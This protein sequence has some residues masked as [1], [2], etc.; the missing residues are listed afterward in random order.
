MTQRRVWKTGEGGT[1]QYVWA[2][3]DKYPR[4][5]LPVDLVCAAAWGD[6]VDHEF[7]GTSFASVASAETY[8][9]AMA[10]DRGWREVPR[11]VADTITVRTLLR[12]VPGSFIRVQRARG[13]GQQRKFLAAW[14]PRAST[15]FPEWDGGA[16]ATAID[17][18]PGEA[19]AAVYA[20]SVPAWKEGL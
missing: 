19:V 15:D 9:E 14:V 18:T 1:R 8:M 20:M 12:A 7:F 13:R 6:F 2:T 11:H 5:L 16:N 17:S 3:R 10:V 4:R